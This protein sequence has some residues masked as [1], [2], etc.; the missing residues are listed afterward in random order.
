MSTTEKHLSKKDVEQRLDWKISRS[1][2]QL[3][4]GTP[5]ESHYATTRMIDGEQHILGVVGRNYQL[6]QNEEILGIAESICRKNKLRFTNAGVVQNGQR[7]FFQC[8]GTP[9][10]VGRGDEVTPYMLF[11]NAHDGSMACRMTPMTE[12]MVCENQL[13]NMLDNHATWV[14]IRHSGDVSEKLKEAGRLSRHFLTVAKANRAAMLRMRQKSVS[15][16]KVADFFKDMFVQH[17]GEVNT[18]PTS[19]PEELSRERAHKAYQK[20]LNRFE[21]EKSIAGATAWNMANAYTGWLQHEHRA[22]RDPQKS[23]TRR[24][25]SSLFGLLADRS[26]HTFQSALNI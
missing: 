2:L 23:A 1:E 5:I 26:V 25:H 14:S 9:F 24:L 19:R 11:V 6:I 22:G 4:D 21:S 10:N 16:K 18:N 15:A 17:F 13:S 12:R 7:V 20:Y 8:A 3:A